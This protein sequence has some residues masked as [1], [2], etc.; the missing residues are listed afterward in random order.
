M[1]KIVLTGITGYKQA[2]SIPGGFASRTLTGIM[3]PFRRETVEI[4]KA[5]DIPAA[6]R[7]FGDGVRAERSPM[8]SFFVGVCMAAGERKPRGF[9]KMTNDCR[10]GFDDYLIELADLN[11]WRVKNGLPLMS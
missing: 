5:E 11:A 10:G 3:N 8:A 1:A 7:A 6:V 2:P 9:D 4:R